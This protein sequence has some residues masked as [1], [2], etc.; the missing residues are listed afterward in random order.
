MNG[1]SILKEA[2]VLSVPVIIFPCTSLEV[3]Q[4]EDDA[5]SQALMLVYGML[6]RIE[7]Q[8]L[9][10]LLHPPYQISVLLDFFVIQVLYGYV[11]CGFL[12]EYIGGSVCFYNC[13]KE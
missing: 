8:V 1:F 2:H 10:R 9:K 4:A 13:P 11:I 5:S 7:S 12:F 3:P 6:F